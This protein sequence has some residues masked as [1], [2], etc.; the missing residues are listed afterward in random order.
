MRRGAQVFLD[1]DPGELAVGLSPVRVPLLAVDEPDAKAQVAAAVYL[2]D[3]AEN[4]AGYALELGAPSV[5]LSFM[6][7]TLDDVLARWH[8]PQHTS[9]CDLSCPDCLRSYDNARRHPLLDWRLATDMLELVVG[10]PLTVARSLPDDLTPFRTSAEGLQ[11]AAVRHI[12]AIPAVVRNDRCVL[13]AHPLWRLDVDWF[14]MSQAEAQ[15]EAAAKFQTVAW[16]DVR[17]FRRNP[18]SVWADLSG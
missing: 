9:G 14:T 8:R 6:E 11:G 15:V 13:L 2:A 12:G 10:R 16:H 3:T 7:K 5:F 1:L 18:L 4:G 17:V